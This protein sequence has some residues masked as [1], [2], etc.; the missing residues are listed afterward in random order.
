M[1]LPCPVL[2]LALLYKFGSASPHH[3]PSS[4]ASPL[5]RPH[6]LRLLSRRTSPPPHTH[7][8]PPIAPFHGVLDE[9]AA[10]SPSPVC[11]CSPPHCFLVAFT[12]P[13][14]TRPHTSISQHS[15]VPLPPPPCVSVWV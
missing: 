7:T 5:R 12:P 15:C 9:T 2:L 1:L 11:L 14:F 3:A 10:A 6:L 13:P 4:V 8:A